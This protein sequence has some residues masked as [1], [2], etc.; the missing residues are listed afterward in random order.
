MSGHERRG[1]RSPSG[2]AGARAAARLR[3][4]LARRHGDA[5][6]LLAELVEIE[7][8]ISLPA[9]VRAVGRTM[10]RELEAAG[11]SCEARP[12][13]LPPLEPWIGDILLPDGRPP[14]IE[15]AIVASRA[16]TEARVLLL[17]D[18]DTAHAPGSLARNPFRVND[19][20]AHGPG[21]ADMKG[22]LVVLALAVR[23]LADAGLAAPAI[24]VVLC[25]DEQAGSP[26]SRAI[27]EAEARAADW[28]LCVECAREGGRVMAS[29]AQVGIGRLDLY[30]RE[31]YAGAD[32]ANGASAVAALARKLPDVDAVTD[33]AAGVFVTVTAIAGGRRRSVVPGHAWCT[34]DMRAADAAGWLGARRALDEIARRP[35]GA[36]TRG[37][38][39]AYAHRPAVPWT[40]ATDELLGVLDSAAGSLGQAIGACASPAAG[41][42]AFAAAAGVP[43]LDGMGPAGGALMTD[44]EYVEVDTLIERAAVLA[45]VLHLLAKPAKHTTTPRRSMRAT[46]RTT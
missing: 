37:E 44:A 43:T 41:S 38:L 15:D 31:A 3:S 42:S 23:A 45:L 21:V 33:V 27:V 13:V 20:R 6:D 16:G 30:G 22:G 9:G 10:S 14:A 35:D 24:T 19:G 32:R 11:F 26:A 29:R 39:H 8:H 1:T 25:P 5:I 18:L 2:R 46:A 17:G 12:C 28:C 34:I 36:G 7:S 4:S 40:D